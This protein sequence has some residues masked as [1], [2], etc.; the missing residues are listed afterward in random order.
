MYGKCV[1]YFHEFIS[2]I[3]VEMWDMFIHLN[4]KCNMVLSIALLC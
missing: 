1:P 4:S 3:A 2:G